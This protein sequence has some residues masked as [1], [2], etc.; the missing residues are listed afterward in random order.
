MVSRRLMELGLYSR[1][2]IHHVTIRLLRLEDAIEVPAATANVGA[3]QLGDVVR[4]TDLRFNT[5][6]R[7]QADAY[8]AA[9]EGAA[10]L[11]TDPTRSTITITLGASGSPTIATLPVRLID[12][13]YPTVTT[14]ADAGLSAPAAVA[15]LADGRVYVADPGSH[16]ILEI[17]PGGAVTPFAGTGTSG[18]DDGAAA[19]ATFAGPTGVA[20]DSL[21]AIFVAD[22]ENHRIRKI[23]DGGIVS[24]VAG[25]AAGSADG[26]GI[27]A[28]FNR[29]CGLAFN[30]EGDLLVADALNGSVRK[31]TA[32]GDVTTLAT[33][34]S[35]PEGLA[36]AANGTIYVSEPAA[37]RVRKVS[38]AGQVSDFVVTGLDG[39]H[40]LACD[41]IGNVMVADGNRVRKLTPDGQVI[42]LAGDAAGAAADGN[43]YH[44][45]FNG[46]L[47]LALSA[48]GDLYV[49][50]AGNNRVR[51]VQ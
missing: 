48:A 7:L 44:A 5:T 20:I 38:A 43:G 31:V 10:S 3:A 15:T 36:V 26:Q 25:A 51:K 9:E 35:A 21:G 13:P 1:A 39:P 18:A 33:G 41:A 46:P 40:G 32:G 12:R 47:G 49:A 22:T 23:D 8:D 45:R 6:Y 2:S 24:T 19:S 29:P 34:L 4:F 16:R 28:S 14:V 27:A 42:Q 17:A 11:I 30:P 37:G 50:D